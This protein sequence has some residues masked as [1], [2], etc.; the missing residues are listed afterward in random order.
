MTQDGFHPRLNCIAI[1][2]LR[3]DLTAGF[4]E[5]MHLWNDGRYLPR[6]SPTAP[7]PHLLVMVNNAPPKDLAAAEMAFYKF[8]NLSSCF[9]GITVLS[10]GLEGDRDLYVK[11]EGQRV[12]KFGSRAGPNF[13]F[14][15][16][17][18]AAA[19][20]GGFCLQLEL[21]CLPIAAGWIEATQEVVDG[22]A[23]A[24]VIGTHFSG[25]GLL[26]HTLQT[27]LNGNALY[28]TGDPQ[29]QRF[30]NT[31]WMPRVL[32]HTKTFVDLA[33]DCWWAYELTHSDPIMNNEG[34]ALFKIYNG[35]FHSNHFIT[36]LLVDAK[37]SRDY[38]KVMHQVL[39]VGVQPVFFHGPA[40]NHIRSELLMNPH[41]S[42]FNVIDRMSV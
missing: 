23:G 19:R 12:G 32:E 9:S 21:D 24:W 39:A 38:V 20:Y 15:A 16:T 14:Q 37:Q 29:F 33:Y 13:L 25:E 36:N 41:E 7:M 3:S 34:W 5:I 28:R 6:K 11:Q 27:H 22:H 40:L 10:A 35:F 30:L 2:L 31:V 18:N 1:P 8:E 42:I 26:D 4:L 17:M